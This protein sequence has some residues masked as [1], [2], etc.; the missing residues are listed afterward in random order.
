MDRGKS[1]R[2]RTEAG[3]E[4]VRYSKLRR[5]GRSKKVGD[6][7]RAVLLPQMR[8]RVLWLQQLRLFRDFRPKEIQ[9][10]ASQ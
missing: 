6:W 1:V 2:Y 5:K 8:L 3:S 4:M 9:T 10:L 7:G